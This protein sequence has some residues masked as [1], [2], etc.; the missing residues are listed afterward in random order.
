MIEPCDGTDSIVVRLAVRR[1]PP[2]T[3][4][5]SMLEVPNGGS[6]EIS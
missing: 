5:T 4:K 2:P 3:S 6:T 1:K